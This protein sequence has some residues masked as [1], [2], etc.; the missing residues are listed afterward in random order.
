MRQSTCSIFSLWLNGGQGEG[1]LLRYR[2]PAAATSKRV[3]S[4]GRFTS[5]RTGRKSAHLYLPMI[6]AIPCAPGLSFAYGS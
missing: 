3:I 6:F 4:T 5:G 1:R 2:G